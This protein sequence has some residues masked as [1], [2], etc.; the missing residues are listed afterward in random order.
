[1]KKSILLCF[2]LVTY[3]SGFSQEF[4]NIRVSQTGSR[5]NIV[6]DIVGSGTIS[7]IDLLYSV[8]DGKSW[9]G[10][11]KN[12]VGETR[13]IIAPATNKLLIWDA[14]AENPGLTGELQFRITGDFLPTNQAEKIVKQD[15]PPVMNDLKFKRAK[16]MKFVF[17]ATTLVAAGTGAYSYQK[18][19]KLYDDYQSAIDNSDELRKQITAQ[20]NILSVAMATTGISLVAAIIQGSR[21][22]KFRKQLQLTPVADNQTTGASLTIFF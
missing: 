4:T 11:L 9:T 19:N 5:I 21:Q 12:V 18:G 6:F 10:P 22:A 7:N 3:L 2:I 8:D 16:S 20:D 17:M 13:N 1:M 14:M 15:T